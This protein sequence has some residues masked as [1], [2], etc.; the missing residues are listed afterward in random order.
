MIIITR[1]LSL[2]TLQKKSREG[3]CKSVVKNCTRVTGCFRRGR[4]KRSDLGER[5]YVEVP[6][7]E[8]KGGPTETNGGWG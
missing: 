5:L 2:S 7:S 3:E 4:G 1:L 8:E 6:R